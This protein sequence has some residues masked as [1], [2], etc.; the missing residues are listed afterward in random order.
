MVQSPQ[1]SSAARAAGIPARY[2]YWFGQSGRR[3]LFTETDEAALADVSGGV[4]IAVRGGAIIWAG[5][6]DAFAALP[7]TAWLRGAEFFV[8]LLA[9]SAGER[10]GL[11]ADFR[12]AQREPVR[13]AA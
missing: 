6:S 1:P 2:V 12:P 8:H 13:L 9:A 5:E 4:V 10:R 11:V 7:R 3:V